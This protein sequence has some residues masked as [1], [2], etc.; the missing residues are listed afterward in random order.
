MKNNKERKGLEWILKYL[1]K[2]SGYMQQKLNKNC[3]KLQI[4]VF[5][6]WISLLEKLKIFVRENQLSKLYSKKHKKNEKQEFSANKNKRYDGK[7]QFFDP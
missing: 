6:L 4:W 7:R 1:I 5:Q 3:S 2:Y